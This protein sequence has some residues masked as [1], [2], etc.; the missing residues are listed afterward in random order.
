LKK[1][2][3]IAIIGLATA[4]NTF[5]FSEESIQTGRAFKRAKDHRAMIPIKIIHKIG[6]PK[7]YHEGLLVEG[8]NV[9]VV[10]GEGGKTWVINSNSGKVI[11]EIESV[12]TFSEGI[13]SAPDGKYWASD[14]DTKKVYLVRREG[15]KLVTES[16]LSLAPSHP[17][18]IAWNGT[19]LYILTWTRG[20]RGTRYH[21]LVADKSGNVLNKVRIKRIPEPSQIT[22]DGKDL[23]ISSWFDRRVYR[24]DIKTFE[25]K[26]Y[27]RSRIEKV[28]GIAWDGK[29]F[30]MT[31][32]K[33]DLYQV[34]FVP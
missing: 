33:E 1:Y 28:T 30:W 2:I 7:G 27:F 4:F 21:I 24:I 13:T 25:I 3:I 23:W 15:S 14:W 5:V 12:A 22:W 10:N 34:E 8:D 11:S 18:G 20:A 16:E 17:T 32:S 26:G 19:N 9:W 31:G 29:S 6:L